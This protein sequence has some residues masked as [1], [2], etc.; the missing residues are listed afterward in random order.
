MISQNSI[1]SLILAKES[2]VVVSLDYDNTTDIISAIHLLG[3]DI[4]GIKLHSD[5]IKDFNQNFINNL[6]SLKKTYN[7]LIIEDRKFADIGTIVSEQAKLIVTY[8]DLITAH[9]LPGPGILSAL[10]YDCIRN[11][12]G[13]LLIAE[14]SSQS[15]LL[16]E[17]YTNSVVDMAINNLDIVVGLIAQKRHNNNLVHFAPGVNLD[18]KADSLGQTYNT[19][20]DVINRGI[21]VLIVGRGITGS[22]KNTNLILA[23]KL[24]GSYAYL[25]FNNIKASCSANLNKELIKQGLVINGGEEF[26]LSS[27]LKSGVYYNMKNLISYPQTM[28]NVALYLSILIKELVVNNLGNLGYPECNLVLAGV[29]LGAIPITS[30]LSLLMDIPM[31]MIRNEVKSHGLQNQIEGNYKNK[32][33]IIIEDV[34]TT[35]K[36]VVNFINLVNNATNGNNNINNDKVHILGVISIINRGALNELVTDYGKVS[37]SS[38]CYV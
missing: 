29:P 9:G 6:K 38:L 27:G 28:C 7:F 4:L 3:N 22:L 23:S 10:R 14:M 13:V 1:N 26:T 17:T 20:K 21:D 30:A 31:I 25:N 24:V 2:N 37:V 15:N 35:G 36:S 11:N 16:N 18:N 34:I 33:I 8:A 12:C 5:I 19:P 32:N